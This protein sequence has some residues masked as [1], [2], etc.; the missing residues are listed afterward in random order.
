MLFSES[1]LKL[2]VVDTHLTV[3]VAIVKQGGMSSLSI[4]WPWF[5]LRV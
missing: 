1:G 2:L 3:Q 5:W 4:R